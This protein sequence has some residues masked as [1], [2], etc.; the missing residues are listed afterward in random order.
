MAVADAHM[1]PG[2]ALLVLA[3]QGDVD[4]RVLL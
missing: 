2:E 1:P 4:C 3:V